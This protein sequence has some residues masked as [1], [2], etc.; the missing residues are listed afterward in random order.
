MAA[1]LLFWWIIGMVIVVEVW[2]RSLNKAVYDW[3][4]FVLLIVLRVPE[5]PDLPFRDEYTQ[6]L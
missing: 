6:S 5:A 3:R 4:A 2:L 1:N